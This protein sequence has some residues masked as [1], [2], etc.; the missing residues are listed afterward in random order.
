MR[1]LLSVVSAVAAMLLA[2]WPAAA[3]PAASFSLRGDY[4]TGS[5][6]RDVL[7][8]S[9]KIPLN[10]RYNELTDE[11]R[12]VLHSYYVALGPGDEPPFPSE[13]LEPLV[14][15]LHRAQLK[16]KVTGPLYLI[17]TVGPDGKPTEVSAVGS[18]SEE[19]TR[20]AASA[21]MLT[22][23]KAAKCSGEPCKMQYPLALQFTMR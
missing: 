7:A 21:V 9:S 5:S 17:A 6:I 3:E 13:G 1:S 20:F 23:F 19:M 22:A 16:L 11:Q 14:K 4:S 10:K 2:S 15:L 8:K 18:P 12:Q